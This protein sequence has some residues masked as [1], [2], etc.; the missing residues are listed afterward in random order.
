MT[1]AWLIIPNLE[2]TL[3][4]S[5]KTMIIIIFILKLI[6]VNGQTDLWPEFGS[7]SI[8]E[9]NFKNIIIIILKFYPYIDKGH[10]LT[11]TMTQVF[12]RVDF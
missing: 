7:R 8:F 11:Q 4:L 2:S 10:W 6:W 1:W 9:S 12:S 3:E 5:F